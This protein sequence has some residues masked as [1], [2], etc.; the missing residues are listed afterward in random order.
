MKFSAGL[1]SAQTI[2][3]LKVARVKASMC[4]LVKIVSRKPKGDFFNYFSVAQDIFLFNYRR[5]MNAITRFKVRFA[6]E[7]T[8]SKHICVY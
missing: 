3:A 6:H 7:L 5:I 2:N 1:F 4:Q 8:Y